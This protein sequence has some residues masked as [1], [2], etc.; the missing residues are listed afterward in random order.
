MLVF[1][2]LISGIL[3]LSRGVLLWRCIIGIWFFLSLWGVSYRFSQQISLLLADRKKNFL[4]ISALGLLLG[5]FIS[6]SWY[7]LWS[8]LAHV[9]QWVDGF[10]TILKNPRWWYG[11]WSSGPG[12]HYGGIVLPENFFLQLW[13][14]GGVFFLLL[15][16]FCIFLFIKAYVRYDRYRFLVGFAWLLSVGLFL[17][18]FEDTMVNLLVCLSVGFLRW[19]E[20][21]HCD[22]LE[23]TH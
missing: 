12:I 10:Q 16:L 19:L 8:T 17:H 9:S 2:F 13:L 4:S 7:K 5:W 15:R 1:L 3:T 21:G 23:M 20:E 6:L 22:K 11:L 14:D 18:I